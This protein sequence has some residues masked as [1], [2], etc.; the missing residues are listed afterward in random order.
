MIGKKW[1]LGLCV[2][3]LLGFGARTAGA[4][5]GKSYVVKVNDEAFTKEDVLKWWRFWREKGMTFPATAEPFVDWVLLSQEA[6]AM[7]LEEE[8]SY[9]RKL[10]V[11]LE[12][13]SLL[14]LR[15]DEVDSK[16]DI[17]PDTL[18]KEYERGYVPRWKVKALITEKKEEAEKWRKEIRGADDFKRLFKTLEQLK[19]AKDFGWERPTTIPVE[20][21]KQLMAAKA[22]EILG[23]LKHKTRYFVL[24]I[25]ERRGPDKEDFQKLHRSIAVKFKKKES[26]R[27]T[28]ELVERLKKKYPVRVDEAAIAKIGLDKLPE[29]LAKKKVL[30]VS[31]R[32][33]TGAQFQ[34]QLKKDVR[35]RIRKGEAPT[36]GELKMFKRGIVN[37]TVSQTLTMWEALNR[38]YEKTK[39]KDIY[40][41]YKRQRLVRELENKV[42]WL[43][44]KVIDEDVK[45]YY[46][47]HLK[48]YTRPARV[49][50]AVIRTQDEKLIRKT[51]KRI[52]DGEDFFEVARD[53]MFHGVRPERRALKNLVPEMVAALRS[54]KPGD[55]SPIIKFKGWFAIVK[56][57]R[58]YP[59]AAHPFKLVKKSIRKDLLKKRFIEAR[60]AYLAK[61]RERSKIEVDEEMWK[62]IKE[63]Q[64]KK[65]ESKKG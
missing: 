21:K 17:N 19:K 32:S 23:P 54:M 24:W 1:I 44:V 25:E 53:V 12:V 7:G 16:I 56:L 6:R 13:R 5:F 42:L 33:M 52:R 59:E 35:L 39:L 57:I 18:W 31:D 61:L 29:D 55:V 46:K 34:A 43:E 27:L 2:V 26:A 47:E 40:T 58:R 22:G 65:D 30:E 48:D 64:E 3:V 36:P 9:K 4:F 28:G 60:K 37:N 38:H 15:Y 51:Y 45:K 62:S 50:I 20:L 63:S 49:E 10:R 8:S 11:F 41:F 14:Q